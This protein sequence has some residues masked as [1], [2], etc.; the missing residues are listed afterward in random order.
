LTMQAIKRATT[1]ILYIAGSKNRSKK[2]TGSMSRVAAEGPKDCFFRD[3]YLVYRWRRD[4]REARCGAIQSQGADLDCFVAEPV[5]GPARGL[6]RARAMGC[7]DFGPDPLAPHN[8]ACDRFV[9]PEAD[10]SFEA[11]LRRAPQDDGRSRV[12][13]MTRSEVQGIALRSIR[14]TLAP[15]TASEVLYSLSD[16]IR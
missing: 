12:A 13:W 7:P 9:T 2:R 16:A 5:I 3:S 6:H 4:S 10:S 14:A 15:L 1:S 8:D 11:R